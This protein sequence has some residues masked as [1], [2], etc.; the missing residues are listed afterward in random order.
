MQLPWA[1]ADFPTLS[2]PSAVASDGLPLGVQI[3]AAPM[4]EAMLFAAGQ[5]IESVIAFRLKPEI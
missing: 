3:I 4:R 1:L 5:A 2:L